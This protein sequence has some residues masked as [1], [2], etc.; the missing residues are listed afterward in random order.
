MLAILPVCLCC[1]LFLHAVTP[2]VAGLVRNRLNFPTKLRKSDEEGGAI[3]L[4]TVVRPAVALGNGL[5]ERHS[6]W[7]VLLKKGPPLRGPREVPVHNSVPTDREDLRET[8]HKGSRVRRHAIVR[9]R[10]HRHGNLM[11]VGCVLGT[12]QVQNLSHRLYQLIGQT[13][14]QETSP[15][16]PR[17]PHSYG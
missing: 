10:S 3:A 17:S 2:P 1:C 12:C 6:V 9:S 11:R 15:I 14:R 13:G 16:N 4:G 7:R 8:S 5:R